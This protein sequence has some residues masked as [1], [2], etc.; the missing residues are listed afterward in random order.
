MSLVTFTGFAGL[1]VAPGDL[2]PLLV[3]VAV[4]C[5]AVGAGAAGAVNMWY[6]RDI[7]A[8]MR[9]TCGRP[10]PAGRV[11]PNEALAFGAILSVGSVMLIGLAVN[12]LAA[13]LLAG[14]N[15]F[16]VFV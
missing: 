11:A 16:Y 13:A 12:W 5:I 10:P 3:F 14:A 1:A 2:H 15:L 4:L 7:D 6:D 9:R 8:V